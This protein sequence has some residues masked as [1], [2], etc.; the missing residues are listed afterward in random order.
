MMIIIIWR[1]IYRKLIFNPI[2]KS[3][4]KSEISRLS[5][6]FSSAICSFLYKVFFNENK[7]ISKL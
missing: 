1:I 3:I 7:I 6:K 2:L 5:L 4:L